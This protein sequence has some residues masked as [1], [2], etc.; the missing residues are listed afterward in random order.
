MLSAIGNSLG[1]HEDSDNEDDGADENYN[2]QCL[3]L[4]MLSEDDKLGC[5]MGTISRTTQQYM[6]RLRQKQMRHD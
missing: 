1:E 6:E 4:G 2:E 3:A 5:V